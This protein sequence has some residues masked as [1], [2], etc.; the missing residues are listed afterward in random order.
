MLKQ[1]LLTTEEVI[2]LL[3][4]TQGELTLTE[5]AEK[6]GCTPTHLCEIYKRRRNIGLTVATFLGLSIETMYKRAA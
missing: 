1:T 6:V 4:K 2:T 3:R 5:F